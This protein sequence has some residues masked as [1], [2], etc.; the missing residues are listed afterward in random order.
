MWNR[1]TLRMKITLLTA[2]ALSI[3]ATGVTGF[4][5]YNARQ[6]TFLP[7]GNLTVAYSAGFFGVEHFDRPFTPFRE[8]DHSVARIWIHSDTFDMVDV[9]RANNYVRFISSDVLQRQEISGWHIRG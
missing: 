7:Q 9:G 3:I 1:I 5:I 2:L 4:S 8:T 6:I